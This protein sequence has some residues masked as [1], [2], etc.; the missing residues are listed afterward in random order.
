MPSRFRLLTLLLM[1]GASGPI[2]GCAEIHP[3][4]RPF[5][6]MGHGR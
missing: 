5:S 3:D 6:P 4:N 1:L 2:A